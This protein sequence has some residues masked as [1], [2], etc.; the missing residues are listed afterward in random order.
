MSSSTLPSEPGAGELDEP[1]IGRP[2]PDAT[3]QDQLGQA[4]HLSDFWGKHPTVFV[5]LRHFG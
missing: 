2:A 3:F 4:I 1:V 5:F